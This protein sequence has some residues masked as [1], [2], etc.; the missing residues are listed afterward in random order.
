MT[1]DLRHLPESELR[2]MAAMRGLQSHPSPRISGLAQLGWIAHEE[3][4]RRG[5]AGSSSI[6]VQRRDEVTP[7]KA[8][9]SRRSAEGA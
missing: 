1:F 4:I 8:T 2:D 6:A 5:A 3:L 9:A 7:W